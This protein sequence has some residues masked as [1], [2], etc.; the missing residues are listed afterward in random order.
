MIEALTENPF[1][2][3]ALYVAIN[4]LILLCLSMLVVRARVMTKTD[5]GDGG[6]SEMMRPLR[7]HANNAEN[8]PVALLMLLIIYSLGGSVWLIHGVG[9]PLTVGRILHAIGLSRSAGTSPGRFI[10]MV[11][12]WLAYIVGIVG[13]IWLAFASVASPAS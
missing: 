13:C 11:L 6:K 2:M 4:A 7:A 3:I 12:T 1:Q 5:I 9:A 10:G 8:I